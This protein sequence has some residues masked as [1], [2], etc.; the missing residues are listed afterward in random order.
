MLEKWLRDTLTNL[1]IILPK[2]FHPINIVLQGCQTHAFTKIG[3][4]IRRRFTWIQNNTEIQ[5]ML[6][7]FEAETV[8]FRL[9][10]K[11]NEH[12]TKEISGHKYFLKNVI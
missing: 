8:F 9:D 3:I 4:S 6:I 2:R 12:L 10:Q 5:Q 1:K 11:T 7:L